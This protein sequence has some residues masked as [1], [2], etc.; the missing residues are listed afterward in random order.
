MLF[1]GRFYWQ[2]PV[3]LCNS[4]R[5]SLFYRLCISS[6]YMYTIMNLLVAWVTYILQHNKQN[7]Q[8]CL[9]SELSCTVIADN[10]GLPGAMY[11]ITLN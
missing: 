7:G 11:C 9:L 5:S 10:S 6:E 4:F 2:P 8:W 1:W 3:P